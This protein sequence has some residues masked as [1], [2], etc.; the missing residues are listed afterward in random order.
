M[1]RSVRDG[2]VVCVCDGYGV[3]AEIHTFRV[4]TQRQMSFT[5]WFLDAFNYA[6]QSRVH[7]LN[8]SIGVRL[9]HLPL[10]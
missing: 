7:V 8:L 5:S 10:C 4:F 6:I 9:A 3:Q 1:R 2:L